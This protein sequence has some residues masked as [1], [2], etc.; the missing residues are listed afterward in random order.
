[1]L[2]INARF[3]Y[4]K[5]EWSEG[6]TCR[7]CLR[8]YATVHAASSTT[9]AIVSIAISKFAIF[10]LLKIISRFIHNYL[11]LTKRSQTSYHNMLSW[12]FK[13][14]TWRLRWRFKV[15]YTKITITIYKCRRSCRLPLNLKQ[16]YLF[17]SAVRELAASADVKR[18]VYKSSLNIVN[19][20]D[21]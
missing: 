4:Y 8:F 10:L 11:Y 1:M 17:P 5:Y 9:S 7:L 21:E 13:L 15:K 19:V 3:C 20:N 18:Q 14:D 16:I 12:I 6:E 2:L